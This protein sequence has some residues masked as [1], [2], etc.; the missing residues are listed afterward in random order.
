MPQSVEQVCSD[1]N[2]I[3]AY[4]ALDDFAGLGPGPEVLQELDVIA[5]ATR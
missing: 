5:L 2:R 1:I 3:S 4:L